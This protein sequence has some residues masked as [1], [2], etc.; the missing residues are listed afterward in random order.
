MQYTAQFVDGRVETSEE[1]E[2]RS[3]T[4]LL[5]QVEAFA[6]RLEMMYGP[7]SSDSD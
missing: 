7:Q 1:E 2:E 3:P 4:N 5:R 6:Q